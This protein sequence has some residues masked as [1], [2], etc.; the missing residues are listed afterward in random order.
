MD[1]HKILP[2]TYSTRIEINTKDFYHAVERADLILPNQDRR[3][4]MSLK[5]TGSQIMNVTATTNVGNMEDGVE[6]NYFDGDE[7][8]IDFNQRYF[9]DALKVINDEN[10]TVEFNGPVGPCIIQPVEGNYFT[11]LILPLRR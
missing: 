4:P 9:L 2:N 8:E 11:Y 3:Y 1:Y 10:V 5:F 6:L 7:L